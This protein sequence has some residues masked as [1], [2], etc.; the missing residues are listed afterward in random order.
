MEITRGTNHRQ[1]VGASPEM[2]LS[3]DRLGCQSDA[4]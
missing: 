1:M 3:S 4:P 2:S